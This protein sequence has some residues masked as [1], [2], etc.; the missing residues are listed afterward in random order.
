[1]SYLKYKWSDKW[2]IKVLYEKKQKKKREKLKKNTQ[3]LIK[4]KV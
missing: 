4:S 3:V 2:K 1:M